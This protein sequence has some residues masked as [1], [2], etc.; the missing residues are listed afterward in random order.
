[1]IQDCGHI[2]GDKVFLVA[3]ADDRRRPIA[4]GNDLVRF[5]DGDDGEREDTGKF[6]YGFA[7]CFLKIGTVS[8]VALE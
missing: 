1:M 3:Q 8:V 6:L 5:V 4:R 2:G 7:D